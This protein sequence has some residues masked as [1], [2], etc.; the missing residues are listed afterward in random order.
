MATKYDTPIR[1]LHKLFCTN[2]PTNILSEQARK[3]ITKADEPEEFLL[4]YTVTGQYI[5]STLS[6]MTYKQKKFISGELT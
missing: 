6:G 1:I 3:N 5:N 2:S 4:I